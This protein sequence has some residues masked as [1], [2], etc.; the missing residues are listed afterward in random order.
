M[1]VD[2]GEE[3]DCDARDGQDVEHGVQE[4]VPDTAAAA[5]GAVDQHSYEINS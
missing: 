4:L 5:A 2:D 3:S 1:E